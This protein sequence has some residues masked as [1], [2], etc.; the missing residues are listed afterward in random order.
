MSPPANDADQ[1]RGLRAIVRALSHRNYRLY[2]GGQGISLVGTWM[3]RIATGWLVF[4][5]STTQDAAFWLGVVGFVGQVPALVL[6]PL[7]GAYVD[8]WDRQRL[9]IITQAL[10]LLQSAGLALVAF[11]GEPGMTTIWAVIGLAFC[12]GL[13]N[14]FDMPGRQAFL[15]EMVTRRED[16][17]NAIAL[18]SSLVNGARLVGPSLAGAV[19][20]L[21]HVG[22]CFVIDAVSYVA[23]IWALLAMNVAARAPVRHAPVWRGM[24]EGFR[25]AFG[26]APIRSILL[27]LA[28]VSFMG[29][30]YTVLMPIFAVDI[31]HGGAYA[32][33]FLTG[34]SGVGALIGALYLAAR[35][36][37]LGL[38][39]MIIVAAACFGVGLIGFGFSPFFGL[40]MALMVLT[41]FGMMVQM[42][43]SNTILQTIVDEDKR[44]RVMSYFSMAFLGS[45]PFGSLFAGILA[46][47]IGAP[48]TVILGGAVCLVGAAMFALNLPRLRELVRPIYVRMGI[49]SE[50][51]A[52][53]GTATEYTT[54]PAQ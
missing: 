50:V 29:M 26:F 31:L 28:L 11:L 32:Y 22:W 17:P 36:S 12:Q 52:G 20:A 8:R 21:T 35:H 1:P 10:S 39:R 7:A 45:A 27:L 14:S 42:A 30:P 25:Y 46:G 47:R 33:G 19:I 4:R 38:G 48:G 15:V 23:V 5:L 53:L 49:L 51:A 6:G 34:A 18:N 44:G 37:V 2:F 40:S 9:L 43:A 24:V 16:L 54:P 3:T 13:I 41:G